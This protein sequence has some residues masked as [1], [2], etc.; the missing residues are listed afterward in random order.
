LYR[1]PSGAL[2][3]SA[4]TVQ[5]AWGL[6]PNHDTETGIPPE[7]ANPTGAIRIGVD[8]NG[9]VRAIQQATV[10][11]FADMGVRPGSLQPELVPATRSADALAPVSRI[12]SPASDTAVAGSMRITGVASDAGGGQVAG[13]EVSLDGGTRW[14]PAKGTEAWWYEGRLPGGPGVMTIL[15]RAVDDSGNLE[16]PGPG[17][18]VRN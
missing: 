6:D 16:K 18:R 8:L 14:H 17:V 7:R 15:S 4:G 5:W 2:V 10:N 12:L 3:F 9:P 13:V 11:L 1:A